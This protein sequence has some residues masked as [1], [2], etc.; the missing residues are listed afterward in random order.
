MQSNL[1]GPISETIAE[2]RES[3]LEQ[4]EGE[5]ARGVEAGVVYL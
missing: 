5:Q 2:D 3:D 1:S 4:V